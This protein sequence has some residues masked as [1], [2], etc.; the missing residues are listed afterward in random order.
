MKNPRI[1][2]K[3]HTQHS[4]WDEYWVYDG[5]SLVAQLMVKHELRHKFLEA[6]ETLKEEETNE[7]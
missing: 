1:V 2:Q 3:N 6:L 4:G 7:D 5:P